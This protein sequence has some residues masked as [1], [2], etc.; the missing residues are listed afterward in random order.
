[1]RFLNIS[2]P[3]VAKDGEYCPNCHMLLVDRDEY[4]TCPLCKYET[5]QGMRQRR[6]E[7]QQRR[8]QVRRR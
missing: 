2:G 1:M 8:V 7:M 6:V 3:G 4:K 5:R